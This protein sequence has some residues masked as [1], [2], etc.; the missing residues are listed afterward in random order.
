MTPDVLD[1]FTLCVLTILLYCFCSGLVVWVL[2][3]LEYMGVR[4]WRESGACAADLEVT[5][6]LI[7]AWDMSSTKNMWSKKRREHL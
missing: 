6:I 5:G 1:A 7:K 2:W 3:S 4:L